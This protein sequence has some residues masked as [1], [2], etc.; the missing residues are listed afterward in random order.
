MSAKITINPVLC[1]AC[2][3]A[4]AFY[5]L[6]PLLYNGL[7]RSETLLVIL[8]IPIVPL[9]LFRVLASFPLSDKKQPPARLIRL[10]SV[11]IAAFAAG[12]ALGIGAGVRSVPI[13][14][15]GIP[16]DTITGIS[17]IVLDDPRPVS[18]DRA[19]AVVSLRM[20]MGQGGVRATAA[21]D[22]TV[23]FRE[24]NVDRLREF[25]RGTEVFA[26]GNLR[27]GTGAY[28]FSAESLHVTASAS[29]LDRFRTGLRLGL[30]QRFFRGDGQWGGLSLALLLGIRD[31]LDTTLA[32][33][34]R[35]AGCSY[36]LALSGMHLAVLIAIISFLLKKPLGLRA[37]ALTG[38]GIIIVYCFIVGPLPSLIRAALMYLLGVVAVLGMFKRDVL[39][40][41]CMAF[42]IQ[43]A[44]TPLAGHSISFI[45]SYLALAGI[46]IIGGMIGNVFKGMV[47]PV[48]LQP[49]AASLGAFI[50]TAGVMA[51]FFNDLRP[52]GIIAGLILAPL[53]M[54]FMVGSML[55]L[56]L[57]LIHPLVSSLMGYPMSLLY[58]LMEKTASLASYVPGIQANP[59]AVLPLSLALVGLLVWL[60]YRCRAAASRL[61]PFA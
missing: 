2:G 30:T 1:A 18:G 36:I 33:Q 34:Y 12:L 54:V 13:T 5:C 7:I 44:V 14:H 56:V 9:S 43:L 25:G 22:I 50:A 40:L 46:I 57:D 41:L 60:D 42:L 23:F 59:F 21:G 35:E 16:E 45:L 37:A 3:T 19:M 20:V 11:R 53:T 24:E 17:G 49:L 38:A 29:P 6:H 32:Q 55:W 51:F 4:V 52:I 10:V 27:A 61:E 31:N 28:T 39:S 8:F 26:D 48:F 47:P 15:F 58:W